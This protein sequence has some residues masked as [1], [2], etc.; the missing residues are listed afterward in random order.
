MTAVPIN[1]GE[2]NRALSRFVKDLPDEQIVPFHKRV[3]FDLL[4]RIVLGTRYV[5]GYTRGNWQ[6]TIGTP[7]EAELQVGGDQTGESTVAAGISALA[8]L[9]PF[10]TTFI[11][12]PVP[13]ILKLESLDATVNT[14]LAESRSQFP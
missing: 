14:A 5:T 12:N 7:A 6:S 10:E 3:H 13:W 11:S 1:L 2:F 8:A 4:S 9:R